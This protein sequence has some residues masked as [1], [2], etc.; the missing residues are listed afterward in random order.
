MQNAAMN[1]G[2]AAALNGDGLKRKEERGAR[3]IVMM[4]RERE[5]VAVRECSAHAG[6]IYWEYLK[7]CCDR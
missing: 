5:S 2:V 1:L 6:V 3:E 4:E 7:I